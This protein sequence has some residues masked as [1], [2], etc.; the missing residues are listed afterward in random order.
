VLPDASVYS[1]AILITFHN[2]IGVGMTLKS[3][4]SL[5]LILSLFGFVP[6]VFADD[7]YDLVFKARDYKN[8]VPVC[9]A[10]AEA[11]DKKVQSY[12]GVMYDTGK[13]VS[14]DQKQ[15]VHWFTKAA[16]QG[17]ADAQNNLGVIYIWN[18]NGAIKDTVEAYAWFNV[19]AA[20]GNKNARINQQKIE[21]IM[22]PSQ[23]EKG[24]ELSK[25][26]YE[27]YVK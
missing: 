21:K 7:C 12:L 3:I 19:A 11:G 13:G 27:K 8:G 25:Q 10:A 4:Q 23:L 5:F 16:E 18:G 14:Q 15:A 9:L 2:L 1:N 22:T 24:Q 26:Y 17:L 6:A 20:Q